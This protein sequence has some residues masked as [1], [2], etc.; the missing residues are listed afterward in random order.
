MKKQIYWS[1]GIMFFVGV[2]KFLWNA[3]WQSKEWYDD[4]NFWY[5]KLFIVAT[6]VFFAVLLWQLVRFL[7]QKNKIDNG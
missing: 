3:L 6:L 7:F 4:F 5:G 2:S 1:F